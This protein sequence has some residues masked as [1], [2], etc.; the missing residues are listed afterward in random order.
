MEVCGSFSISY[1]MCICAGLVNWLTKLV[2]GTDFSDLTF[3]V[4]IKITYDHEWLI[5]MIKSVQFVFFCC[6]KIIN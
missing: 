4:K 5:V 2:N 1:P 3:R 6:Q